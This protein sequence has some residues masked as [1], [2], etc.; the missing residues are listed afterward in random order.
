ME[1]DSVTLVFEGW[2]PNLFRSDDDILNG[3]PFSFGIDDSRIHIQVPEGWEDFYISM[4]EYIFAGYDTA[5]DMWAGVEA[6][7][8]EQNGTEP[9]NEEILTEVNKRLVVSHN[10]I[11]A[12]M[13]LDPEQVEDNTSDGSGE[14]TDTDP[15]GTTEGTTEENTNTDVSG[16]TVYENSNI[17]MVNTGIGNLD[18][19]A[20]ENTDADRTDSDHEDADSAESE[21]T[22]AD[23]DKKKSE[24][25]DVATKEYR[26]G[27]IPEQE[28]T[29]E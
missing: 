29:Q 2:A 6:D 15:D 8:A 9:T 5:E 27:L 1:S 7:L 18:T 12:M 11:R 14:T 26:C 24:D 16:N 4:W 23:K 3:V 19:A 10:R 28:D 17:W 22:S 20:S 21:D 25:A 13:G